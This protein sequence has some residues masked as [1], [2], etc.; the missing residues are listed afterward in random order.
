MSS[1]TSRAFAYVFSRYCE[2]SKD[3]HRE[4][5]RVAEFLLEASMAR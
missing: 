3:D 1:S 5:E 2:E 4:T